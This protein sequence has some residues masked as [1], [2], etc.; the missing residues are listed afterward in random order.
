MLDFCLST[1]L[2][3]CGFG[4]EEAK[5]RKYRNS[6]RFLFWRLDNLKPCFSHTVL[7]AQKKAAELYASGATIDWIVPYLSSRYGEKFFIED[8]EIHAERS[9]PPFTRYVILDKEGK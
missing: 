4:C 5:K 1:P 3:G 8:N 6:L 9:G 2:R 7:K